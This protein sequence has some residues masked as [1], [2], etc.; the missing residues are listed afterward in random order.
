[1]KTLFFVWYYREERL[2]AHPKIH[3]SQQYKSFITI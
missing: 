3:L 1:M 2:I